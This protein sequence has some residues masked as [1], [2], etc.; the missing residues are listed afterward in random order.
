MSICQTG[1]D[2]LFLLIERLGSDM[3][4]WVF[5]QSD[6]W[7]GRVEATPDSYCSILRPAAMEAL[8]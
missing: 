5:D 8:G 4:L 6:L 2:K 1:M 3:S 7:G